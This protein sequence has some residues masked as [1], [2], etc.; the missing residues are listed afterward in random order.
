MTIDIPQMQKE[1]VFSPA[2]LKKIR[3][4]SR[5]TQ[6]QLAERVGKSRQI[7]NQYEA[8][9]SIPTMSTLSELAKSLEVDIDD[10]L[11]SPTEQASMIN[12]VRPLGLLFDQVPLELDLVSVA[13]RA[14]FVELGGIRPGV[15]ETVKLY[16]SSE[17][18]IEHY[19]GAVVFEVNG[20]SMEDK[21]YS[22]DRVIAWPVP[23]ERWE[24]VHN[25]ICIVAYDDVLTVKAVRENDIFTH[26]RLTL[27]A[28]NPTSGYFVVPRSSI[29]SMWRVEEFFD[30]PKIRL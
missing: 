17:A 6:A 2:S 18:E 1:K 19:Q 27:Y 4:Q 24:Q 28:Y 14:S 10:F 3:K 12:D 7:I 29:R 16:V 23:E 20:D 8:G 11:I 30:R 25:K 5:L 26:N 22:G 21:L 15:F 13:A 9:A